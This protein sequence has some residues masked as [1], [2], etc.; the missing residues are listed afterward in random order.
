MAGDRI[1]QGGMYISKLQTLALLIHG[2]LKDSELLELPDVRC[3]DIEAAKDLLKRAFS[4]EGA[5]L[6]MLDSVPPG[7]HEIL[8][9]TNQR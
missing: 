5:L 9:G 6:S 7:R 1:S 3:E 4:G 2:G 8:K